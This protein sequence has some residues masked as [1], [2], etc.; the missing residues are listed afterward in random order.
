MVRR[1][2]L[3]RGGKNVSLH[4]SRNTLAWSL[5]AALFALSAPA[6][7]PMALGA[8]KPGAE[9]K[10]G[11]K[12]TKHK[13]PAR[14]RHELAKEAGIYWDEVIAKRRVRIA[15]RRN[16]EP[17]T[18]EDYVLSQPPLYIRPLPPRPPHERVIPRIPVLADFLR[19]AAT[20]HGFVPERA[21]S[22]MAFK[23]AYARAALAA[24]LTADQAVRIYAFE[25]GG[26]GTYDVQAGLTHKTKKARA[27]S[28]AIGYNQLLSTNSVGLLAQ[29]GDRIVA[30]LQQ[31]AEMLSD[32]EKPAMAR[33]IAA[34]KRMI[35]FSRTV[36]YHWRDHDKL[37]K[38]TL[39]GAGLHAALIDRDVGPLLQTLKLLD[40]VEFARSKG[41][42]ATLTAAELELMNLT[43]DGNGI[44]LVTMPADMRPLVPTSNFFQEGGYHRNPIARRTGVVSALYEAID[45]KMDR[46]A[47]QPGAQD[48][49]AAFAEVAESSGTLEASA[50]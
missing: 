42:T 46:A 8:A 37:A 6:S 24:G 16:G 14:P 3:L 25:T 10:T 35:A 19:A 26:N 21:E 32:D 43:G 1:W 38:T 49:A 48:M 29:H 39:G 41:H 44:D 5:A 9:A 28:P 12:T 50:R 13:K 45:R 30:A 33:K 17:I 20:Q 2:G 34:L 11:K 22:E 40:S 23:Q 36:P 7:A 4:V 31:K 15:K 47:R 18:L 27:I